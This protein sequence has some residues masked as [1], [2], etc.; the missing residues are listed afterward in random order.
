MTEETSGSVNLSKNALARR[1]YAEKFFGQVEAAIPDAIIDSHESWLRGEL[2]QFGVP[3]DDRTWSHFYD[4]A[5]SRSLGQKMPYSLGQVEQRTYESIRNILQALAWYH[6]PNESSWN[7]PQMRF[8]HA[9][10][11]FLN[12]VELLPLMKRGALR[13]KGRWFSPMEH[14][15]T[16]LMYLSDTDDHPGSSFV[17]TVNQHYEGI[18]GSINY[19]DGISDFRGVEASF[20]PITDILQVSF[21]NPNDF[22]GWCNGAKGESEYRLRRLNH[23]VTDLSEALAGGKQEM[24]EV[25]T[26]KAY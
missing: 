26:W 25:K 21:T 24:I 16:D 6:A 12:H 7:L 2:E 3:I 15:K 23:L 13:N 19:N 10:Q 14:Y 18:K 4:N 5:V 9:G 11:I 8:A 1:L 17:F 20:N 22:M